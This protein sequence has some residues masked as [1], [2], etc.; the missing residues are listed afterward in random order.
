VQIRRL[1]ITNFRSFSHFE[2]HP[3]PGINVVIGPGDAGK[4]SILDA[5]ALVF[6]QTPSQAATEVDYKDLDTSTPFVIEAIVGELSDELMA[7]CYPP[8][9]WGW[10]P[11]N[12]LHEAPDEDLGYEPVLR[13]RV[14]GTDDLELQHELIQPGAEARVLT[15]AQ[16]QAIGLWNIAGA[17]GNQSQLRMGQGSLLERAVGRDN[18]RGPASLALQQARSALAIPEE[19]QD[20]LDAVRDKLRATGI[21]LGQ[22]S[23]AVTP[24]GSQ[25]PVQML[26]LVSVTDDGYVPLSSYGR[27]SQ[28][29]A[30]VMLA[31]EDAAA[32]PIA[33]LDELEAGLEPYRQRDLVRSLR[34][35]VANNGQAFVT[36]HSGT[37]LS[38]MQEGEVWRLNVKQ[39]AIAMCAVE[40]L[41][42]KAL[43]RD[44]EILL[45]RIPV[46]CEGQTEVGFMMHILNESHAGSARSFDA[47]G[48]HCIDGN[49]HEPALELLAALR[50]HGLPT[51]GLLDDEEFKVGTRQEMKDSSD[52]VLLVLP[53]GSC[54]EEA[55]IAALPTEALQDLM[56]RA[57]RPRDGT[58]SRYQALTTAL[59]QQEATTDL[60]ALL[61][62]YGE[63][64]VRE[65]L[66]KTAIDSSWFKTRDG[67]RVLA[68]LTL[69][70]VEDTQ[71]LRQA[72]ASF[73]GD[74]LSIFDI[75]SD[76]LD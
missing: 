49:G 61:L 62:K 47:V 69:D 33:V 59:G 57:V 36:T 55:V 14:T 39:D 2:W 75:D 38:M 7:K 37:V 60:P 17:R 32:S 35:L 3:S 43:L 70:H 45:C 72:I 25:T 20:R 66:A 30:M 21:A 56:S 34:D 13:V 19:S 48:V 76:D 11:N 58:Q 5:V 46:V 71:E 6:S 67:G 42:H 53:G 52:V 24:V 41:L 12:T 9:L 27:G 73:V 4:T 28:Q 51:L 29:I 8:P 23:L 22:L 18:L 44:P 68:S 26:S 64:T 50:Q 40:G 10:S 63:Q 16:R 54:T 15:L 74:I 65:C 31:T 1:T